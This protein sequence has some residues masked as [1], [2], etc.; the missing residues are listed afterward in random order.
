M[1]AEIELKRQKWDSGILPNN[2]SH[3]IVFIHA[4]TFLYSLDRIDRQLRVISTTV[5]GRYDLSPILATF[6]AAVPDLRGVRNS[7]A[8]HDERSQGLSRGKQ[9]TLK[10]IKNRLVNSPVGLVMLENLDGSRFGST[11]KDGLYGE[12]DVILATLK[13]TGN[14]VQNVIS[15]FE[16]TGPPLHWPK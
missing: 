8:H 4:K 3:K 14:A 11:M 12:V 9:I 5:S 10:P 16:W 15:V 1:P 13:A 6:D 7:V 2:Y